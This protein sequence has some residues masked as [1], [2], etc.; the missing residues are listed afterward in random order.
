MD[1]RQ[2]FIKKITLMGVLVVIV[3][4]LSSFASGSSGSTSFSDRLFF[5]I[6][7]ALILYIPSRVRQILGCGLIMSIVV[8]L[9]YWIAFGACIMVFP[10]AAAIGILIPIIDI[11][12]SGI[13]AFK[14]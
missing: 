4:I 1:S 11:V 10:P 5:A 3:L 9:V 13:K 12:W 6:L 8:M 14:K 7:F 2:Q